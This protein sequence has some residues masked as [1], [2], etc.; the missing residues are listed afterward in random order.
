M[1]ILITGVAGF[2]GFNFA[3]HLLSK[4]YN[5]YGIDNFDNY[6]SPK[7]KHL[8]I[9]ELKKSK[10]FHFKKIDITKKKILKK[11]FLNK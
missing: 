4:K 8:R 3:K 2:I 6:Y 7:F 5:I 9:K 10:K 11:Y 1:K